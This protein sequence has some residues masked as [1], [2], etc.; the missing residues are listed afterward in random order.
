M[1]EIILYGDEQLRIST[2][3]LEDHYLSIGDKG[4]IYI[5]QNGI[6]NELGR[7]QRGRLEGKLNTIDPQILFVLGEEGISVDGLHV[8]I[9][10]AFLEQER[11]FYEHQR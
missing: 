9:S 1:E 4:R 8:A 11:M 6:L 7:T 10:Q 3:S 2:R 5:L